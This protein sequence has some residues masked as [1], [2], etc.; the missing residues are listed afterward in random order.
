MARHLSSWSKKI[1]LVSYGGYSDYTICAVY[2]D[3]AMAEAYVR[4]FGDDY[5]IETFAL[6]VEVDQGQGL[7]RWQI[8]ANKSGEVF[9]CWHDSSFL[10]PSSI[11]YMI[12]NSEEGVLRVRTGARDEKHAIEIANDLRAQL[13]ALDRW[14]VKHDEWFQ[15]DNEESQA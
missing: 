2:S 11:Q 12:G 4:K 13:I 15:W 9:Q 14:V 5:R 3:I 7:V 1:H 10:H 6:D 8:M